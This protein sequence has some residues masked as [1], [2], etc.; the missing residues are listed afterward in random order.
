M[1]HKL[2]GLHIIYY[3]VYTHTYHHIPHLLTTVNHKSVVF[4]TI[5]ANPTNHLCAG[6]AFFIVIK[7]NT[8]YIIID[9]KFTDC[10][11][12]EK[13]T[14]KCK[15]RKKARGWNGMASN[16]NEHLH[17]LY[18]DTLYTRTVLVWQY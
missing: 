3:Y 6:N 7:Y 1:Q 17:F 13:R 8:D 14:E 18:I 12:N 11:Q 10:G 9:T 16:S 5:N 15:R 2:Y 4:V